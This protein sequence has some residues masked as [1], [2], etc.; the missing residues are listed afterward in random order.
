MTLEFEEREMKLAAYSKG[1]HPLDLFL[2]GDA[3]PLALEFM[4]RCMRFNPEERCSAQSALEHPFVVAFN[5]SLQA[6]ALDFKGVIDVRILNAMR[7]K[8]NIYLIY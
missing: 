1:D 5:N 6:C 7:T 3:S 8:L 2:K 4:R